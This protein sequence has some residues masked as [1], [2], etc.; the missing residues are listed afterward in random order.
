MKIMENRKKGYERSQ[1]CMRK[2]KEE[3]RKTKKIEA[4]MTKRLMRI[5]SSIYLFSLDISSILS[6]SHT[7]AHVFLENF[8]IH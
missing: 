3:R 1:I 5:S 6:L 8:G 2:L 4:L 7:L